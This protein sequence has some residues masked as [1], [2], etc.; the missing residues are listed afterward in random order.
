MTKTEEIMELAELYAE[1]RLGIYL[2]PTGF[3]EQQEFETSGV[4]L[5]AA[6]EE[7]VADAAR[8]DFQQAHINYE[9][10]AEDDDVDLIWVTY[11]I[12]GRWCR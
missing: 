12:T 9:F 7:L 11:K 2:Q 1:C 3:I 5:K 6:I 8:I 10:T 4:A